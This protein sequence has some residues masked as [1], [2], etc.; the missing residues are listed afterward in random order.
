M[1]LAPCLLIHVIAA[2][3]AAAAGAQDSTPVAWADV[4]RQPVEWYGQPEAKA[5]ADSVRRYQ[6]SNGGWPKDIDMTLPP[7]SAPARG[8][9][10]ST[11]D[12]GATVTQIRLLARVYQAGGDGRDLHSILRG[13]DY[14]LAAQYPNGGWPQFYP[15]RSDYSRY[16]TFN[17]NAMIGVMTL[18]DDVAH[19]RARLAFVDRERRTKAAAAV[20][21]GIDLILRAQVRVADRLTAWCAQHDEVTLEPR[22]ARTYEHASLSGFE[23]VGI[24]RFLMDR[25][26]ADPRILP[27]VDAAVA[28]LEAVKLEGWRVEQ[29]PDPALPGGFDRVMVRDPSAPLLWARFYDIATNR[30]IFSGRDGV[31][32]WTLEEI[33]HERRVGYVWVGGWP[34]LLLSTEYPAWR[35]LQVQ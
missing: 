19:R 34:R 3:A 30:P 4:L 20:A 18:L 15:L 27:A 22:K 25:S 35:G 31:I 17:D 1:K 5:V 14:L 10:D 6:R 8:A 16:I 11:I 28:W 33:E 21:R 12:N 24:V 13:L 2:G 29:R 32:R 7:A 9:L 23:T 26:G